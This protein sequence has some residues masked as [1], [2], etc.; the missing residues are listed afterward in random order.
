MSYEGSFG[1]RNSKQSKF[2]LGRGKDMGFSF[3]L[4]DELE[5]A[6]LDSLEEKDCEASRCRESRPLVR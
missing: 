5:I 1:T 4:K 3:I 2:V 6:R